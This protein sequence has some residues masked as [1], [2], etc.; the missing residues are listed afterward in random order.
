MIGASIVAPEKLFYGVFGDLAFFY[1]LNSLGNRHIGNNLRILLVNNGRGTEFRN[2]NHPAARFGE[3]ADAYMAAAGHYG[4]QSRALIRHYSEDLGFTYLSASTKDEFMAKVP[5]FFA[6]KHA[7]KSIV[8]EV[9]TDSQNE[10][11]AL[12]TLSGIEKNTVSVTKNIVKKVIG[13]EGVYHLRKLL[14]K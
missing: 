1:D 5:E 6:E 8:F 11:D 7:S 10:N 2:Y 14:N 3:D 9:F 12:K 13:Q 4:N